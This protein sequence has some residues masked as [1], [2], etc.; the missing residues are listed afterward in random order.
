MARLA[1]H[2]LYFARKVDEEALAAITSKERFQA[3]RDALVQ[4]R[5][6]REQ[7]GICL[8]EF[9]ASWPP[10]PFAKIGDVF[11]VT[12]GRFRIKWSDSWSKAENKGRSVGHHYCHAYS[13]R[14]PLK[15]S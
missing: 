3:I 15:R 7:I 4:A 5:T 11:G 9:R 14:K 13:A 10:V 8:S 6:W 12:R 2:D 1:Y